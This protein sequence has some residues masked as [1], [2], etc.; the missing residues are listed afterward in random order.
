MSRNYIVKAPELAM[1]NRDR[2]GMTKSC[3][4]Y[5]CKKIMLVSDIKNWTDNGQ[6]AICPLCDTDCILA[7][8]SDPVTEDVLITIHKHWLTKSEK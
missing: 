4:C 5:N 3:G 8:V 2:L 1:K 7:E 6:T